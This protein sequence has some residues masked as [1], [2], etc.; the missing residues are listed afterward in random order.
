M[1][2]PKHRY[3]ILHRGRKVGETWAVSEE[4]AA[5]NYWWKEH[6]QCNPYTYTEWKPSDF[7]VVRA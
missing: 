2:Q 4:K 7:D 5:N 6:K 3:F 1:K